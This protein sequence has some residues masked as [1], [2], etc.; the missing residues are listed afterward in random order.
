MK[1]DNAFRHTATSANTSSWSMECYHHRNS[2]TI[3]FTTHNV[4]P[5]GEGSRRETSSTYY[6]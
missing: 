3:D 5:S 1:Y 4:R 2:I 6:S